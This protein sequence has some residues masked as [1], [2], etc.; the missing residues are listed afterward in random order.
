[1]ETLRATFLPFKVEMI[2][3]IPLSYNIP[4]DNNIWLGN[5][6]GEFTV[7]SAYHIAHKL[8]DSMEEGESSSGDPRT[9]LWKSL[10]T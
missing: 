7:K 5:K 6:K 8:I 3:K 4:E 10:C 9:P 2:L 1:M